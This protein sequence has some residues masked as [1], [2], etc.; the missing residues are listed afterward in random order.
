MWAKAIG[1]HTPRVVE[2]LLEKYI[3]S[4]AIGRRVGRGKFELDNGWQIQFGTEPDVAFLDSEGLPQIVIEIKG[5][6]DVAGAQTRYWEAKKSFAK[7]LARNPR[8]HTVY[9]ASCY[10]DA[11]IEQVQRDGQVREWFNLTSIV[12]DQ[13]ERDLFLERLFHIVF[14]P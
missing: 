11:V 6:L 1:Q 5:S 2:K 9:L 13:D 8:C 3:I 7:E 4:R 14:A 10:T 12:H